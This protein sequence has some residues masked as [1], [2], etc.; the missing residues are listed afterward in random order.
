[1]SPRP[2]SDH[3]AGASLGTND[4]VVSVPTLL[5]GLWRSTQAFTPPPFH[6]LVGEGPTASSPGRSCSIAQITHHAQGPDG[7][8]R[9]AVADLRFLALDVRDRVAV[10]LPWPC[11]RRRAAVSR[12]AGLLPGAGGDDRVG[13]RWCGTRRAGLASAR[14][15]GVVQVKRR[16]DPW[17]GAAVTATCS[18]AHRRTRKSVG[19]LSRPSS[20]S[21]LPPASPR[22]GGWPCRTACRRP[23]G[24]SRRC[25]SRRRAVAEGTTSAEQQRST[26]CSVHSCAHRR[27]GAINA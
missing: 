8:R 20:A 27:S 14:G 25:I 10:E 4:D 17:R 21:R 13:S 23:S 3:R 24:R 18:Q 5:Q 22:L 6:P 2:M 16:A 12:M 1:M 7:N 26:G 11:A 15:Q 19:W 9:R